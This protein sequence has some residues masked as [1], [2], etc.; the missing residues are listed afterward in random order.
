MK[1]GKQKSCGLLAIFVVVLVV[2]GLGRE[3]LAVEIKVLSAGAV[4]SAVTDLAEAFRRETGHEVTVYSAGL[5][6]G[7]L[8]PTPQ[9]PSSRF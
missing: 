2:C 9:R 1:R 7:P 4:K 6:A 8:H 5:A 3:A